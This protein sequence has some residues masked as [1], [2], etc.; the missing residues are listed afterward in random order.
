MSYGE[1][2]Q[3]RR[4]AGDDAGQG[5][6]ESAGS[7]RSGAKWLMETVGMPEKLYRKLRHEQ[8]IQWR[9]IGFGWSF[10]LP[11]LRHRTEMA[12]A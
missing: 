2:E 3:T 11:G 4:M 5:A 9:G 8:G 1:L 10:S 6:I 12:G 7:E